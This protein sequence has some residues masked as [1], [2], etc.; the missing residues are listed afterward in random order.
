[1]WYCSLSLFFKSLSNAGGRDRYQKPWINK[2]KSICMDR[3]PWVRTNSLKKHTV[4]LCFFS[5]TVSMLVFS[6]RWAGLSAIALGWSRSIQN[7][8]FL[9]VPSRLATSIL[10]VSESVQYSFLPSQSQARPSGLSSPDTT[11]VCPVPKAS[12]KAAVK[13]K[14]KYFIFKHFQ[15]TKTTSQ[16]PNIPKLVCYICG[17]NHQALCWSSNKQYLSYYSH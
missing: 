10:L 6:Y 17:S 15:L 3:Y 14:R 5:C 13:R 11:T 16:P 4:Q 2:T 8:T 1:M 7:R 9:E 12:L